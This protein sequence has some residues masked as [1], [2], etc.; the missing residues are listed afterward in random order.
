[1]GRHHHGGCPHRDEDRDALGKARGQRAGMHRAE[2]PLLF[3]RWLLALRLYRRLLCTC[4]GGHAMSCRRGWDC[5]V[6]SD[7]VAPGKRLDKV[8]Q[9][10]DALQGNMLPS[11]RPRF[12]VMLRDCTPK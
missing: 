8:Q 9:P 11:G 10:A 4:R 2:G 6:A 12:R 1:M 7:S 5:S 3:C